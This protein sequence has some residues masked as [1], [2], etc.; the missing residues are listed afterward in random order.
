MGYA[1][2][3]IAKALKS[4]RENKGLSQRDL[5]KKAGVPQGHISRIENGSVDLRLSSLVALGRAL[6]LELTLVPRKT[7]PAIQ[8]IVRSSVGKSSER[9]R[10]VF[11]ELNRIQDSIAQF[12]KTSLLSTELSQLQRQVRGLQ[13]FQ[14]AP[15]DMEALK[16]AGKTLKALNINSESVSAV[17]KSLSQ[18]QELRNVLVHGAAGV[19]REVSARPAYSLDE[20]DYD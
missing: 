9:Q 1:T 16:A 14:F 17:R 10:Q 2:E 19:S 7:V 12:P 6:D 15:P 11:K 8:S 13:S 4:A 20:D 3:H 5:S 18:F